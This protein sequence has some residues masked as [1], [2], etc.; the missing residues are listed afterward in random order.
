MASPLLVVDLSHPPRHPDLV[1]QELMDAWGKVRNSRD[2]C[3][4]KIIHGHGSSG[5]GGTTK[6]FVRNWGFRHR[7]LFRAVIPGEQ[8]SLFDEQ[9]TLL[10]S[11]AG[12]YSDT[13]LGS[14]NP[15]ITI[16][17]VKDPA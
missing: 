2:L 4:L 7:R 17:W 1:E 16:F 9:T 11:S 13:D 12:M 10:R 15:G 5:K 3:V 6:E 14:S 8:Y